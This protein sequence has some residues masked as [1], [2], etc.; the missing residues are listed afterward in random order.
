MRSMCSLTSLILLALTGRI[1][2]RGIKTQ[3][4]T[5]G[6]GNIAPFGALV[7]KRVRG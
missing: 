1:G 2:K 3:G 5:L 4:V 6:Y 7:A